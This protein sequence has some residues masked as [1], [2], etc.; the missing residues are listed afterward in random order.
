MQIEVRMLEMWLPSYIESEVVCML[1]GLLI[2][3]LYLSLFINLVF[4]TSIIIEI[5][6]IT[7]YLYKKD[8]ISKNTD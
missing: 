1:E 8:H 7:I 6:V 4:A 3:L 5:I 2:E